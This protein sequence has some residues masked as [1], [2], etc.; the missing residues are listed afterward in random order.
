MD[1]TKTYV[2]NIIAV[3]PQDNL[4]IKVAFAD[5][6][7][8]LHDVK[9]YLKKFKVFEQLLDQELFSKASPG[10]CGLGVVWNDTI[11]ISP[12]DIWEAGIPIA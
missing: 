10:E 1:I 3:V 6:T 7:V 9:P 2:P 8:K 12:Y 11:D 5:G 4:V